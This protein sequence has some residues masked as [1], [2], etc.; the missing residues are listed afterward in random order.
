MA[1]QVNLLQIQDTQFHLVEYKNNTIF[2]FLLRWLPQEAAT[3]LATHGITGQRYS[4][5]GPKQ[6]LA[7]AKC[8]AQTAIKQDLLFCWNIFKQKMTETCW[9]RLTA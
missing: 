1:V 4:K 3:D 9:E 2:L 5:A 7:T 6:G 8:W